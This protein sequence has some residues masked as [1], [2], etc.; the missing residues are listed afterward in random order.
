MLTTKE[1]IDPSYDCVLVDRI[2][3]D[4]FLPKHPYGQDFSGAFLCAILDRTRS[5]GL[6]I[7]QVLLGPEADRYVGRRG[8]WRKDARPF[9][10]FV[11]ILRSVQRNEDRL[12]ARIGQWPEAI[13]DRAGE[14]LRFLRAG[15]ER[16]ASRPKA[17]ADAATALNPAGKS[18]SFR[19]A[20]RADI[21]R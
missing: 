21:G 1:L 7:I 9:R 12:W 13:Q 19:S 18:W 15:T 8:S 2:V 5:R 11:E 14:A 20:G 4:R 16:L 17:P 6:A 3:S 10:P